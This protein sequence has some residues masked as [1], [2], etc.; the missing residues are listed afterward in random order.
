[1]QTLKKITLSCKKEIAVVILN[2]PR[3]I[4][5]LLRSFIKLERGLMDSVIN[6]HL[7][8]LTF[9]LADEFSSE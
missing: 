1:M 2:K 6:K 5:S 3:I 4:S 9:T 7:A 8:W